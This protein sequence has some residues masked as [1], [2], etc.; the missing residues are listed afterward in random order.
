MREIA[1]L[2]FPSSVQAKLNNLMDKNTEGDL[3]PEERE[4]LRALVELNELV[5]ILKGQAQLLLDLSN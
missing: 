5:S 4:E 3:T 2:T 1:S